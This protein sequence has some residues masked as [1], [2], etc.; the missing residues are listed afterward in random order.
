M[1]N[2]SSQTAGIKNELVI[3]RLL[4]APRELVWK[5]LTDPEM[6]KK[7]WG[8]KGVTNPICEIEARPQ[9]AINIVM[10]A[11]KEL[12]DLAGNKWLMKGFFREVTAPKRLVYTSYAFYDANGE[13]PQLENFVIVTL[14]EQDGKT[15]MKLNVF[16]VKA[17]AEIA[18]PLSGMKTGWTQSI[19]KLGELLARQNAI[20]IIDKQTYRQKVESPQ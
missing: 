17:T 10:L 19:D 14:K 11:G 7:W 12:G 13:N 6:L 9:G 5:A 3:E 16:V 20:K 8:P 4:N 2:K 15:K 1:N 18:A